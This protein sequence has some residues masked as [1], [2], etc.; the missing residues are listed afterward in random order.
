[1]ENLETSSIASGN[2]LQN[3]TGAVEYSMAVLQKLY[4]ESLYDPAIPILGIYPKE[5]KRYV[6]TKICS[7]QHYS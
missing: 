5:L 3:G 2:V 1:M 4:I 6:S 7:L